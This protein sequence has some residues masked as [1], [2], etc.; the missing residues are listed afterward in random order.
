MSVSDPK[1]IFDGL[2]FARGDLFKIVA[3]LTVTL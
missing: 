1:R 2:S 3:D